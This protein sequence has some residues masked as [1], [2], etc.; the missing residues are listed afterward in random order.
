MSSATN[1]D[2]ASLHG[3]PIDMMDED[4]PD[5]THAGAKTEPINEVEPTLQKKL[6]LI[7]LSPEVFICILDYVRSS[8]FDERTLL[9]QIKLEWRGWMHS[10]LLVC[11]KLYNLTLPRLYRQLDWN[12]NTTRE[13]YPVNNH[14]ILRMLSPDNPGLKFIRRISLF[15]AHESFRSPDDMFEYPH[16]AMLAHLLPENILTHFEWLSWNRMPAE[17]YRTLLSRQRA[18]TSIEL[19]WS[20]RPISEMVQI[21]S[22]SLLDAFNKVEQLRVMPGPNEPLL[23]VAWDFFRSHPEIRTLHL[24]FSHMQRGKDESEK[25]PLR[26]SS[27]ALQA[28]F[29]GLDTSTAVLKSLT[30]TG[31]DLRGSHSTAMVAIDLKTLSELYLY[32]CNDTNDFLAALNEGS[33]GYPLRLK[34]FKLYHARRWQ[35]PSLTMGDALSNRL[36][37]EVNKLLGSNTNT[38]E[39]FWICLRGYD[40]LPDVSQIIGHGKTLK[41]LFIDVRKQKGPWAI[42]YSHPEWRKLCA[43][44]SNLRRLDST[45]PPVVADCKFHKHMDFCQHVAN[46]YSW[47]IDDAAHD[48]GKYEI[49]GESE[50]DDF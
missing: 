10:V 46:A 9:T 49:G 11:K 34:Y 19:N 13:G 50:D 16:A 6:Q 4:R 38:L 32:S 23:Q 29:K 42:N 15:D 40:K 18:L 44:I 27:G 7:D 17:I 20:D 5:G 36:L 43:H 22:L 8:L 48:V 3:S 37:E 2:K 12:M 33:A 45:Y 30:L 31:V 1:D 26:S 47:R 41:W 28:F 24:D 25:D 35:P 14:R 39:E 21:G